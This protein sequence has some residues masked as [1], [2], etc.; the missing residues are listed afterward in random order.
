MEEEKKQKTDIKEKREREIEEK[1][2]ENLR[3]KHEM[4]MNILSRKDLQ[5]SKL[6]KEA[7]MMKDQKR[8]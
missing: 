4:K 7:S 8:V 1:R 3:K 2:Q 6:K 5:I